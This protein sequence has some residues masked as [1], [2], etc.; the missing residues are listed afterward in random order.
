MVSLTPLDSYAPITCFNS[1][2][3]QNRDAAVSAIALSAIPSSFESS[4]TEANIRDFVHRAPLFTH[5]RKKEE[6]MRMLEAVKKK[7]DTPVKLQKLENLFNQG[8]M[9]I[10]DPLFQ[11]PDFEELVV[12][13]CILG[14]ITIDQLGTAFYWKAALEHYQKQEIL[15]IPLFIEGEVNPDAYHY[16]KKT[17]QSQ[18]FNI[19]D[20]QQLQNWFERMKG[21]PASEQ[22]FLLSERRSAGY[23]K[24]IQCKND[25][26]RAL[27]VFNN[28][29]E[30]PS[31]TA[32]IMDLVSVANE[33]EKEPDLFNHVEIEGRGAYRMVSSIGM[34]TALH[35]EIE[36]TTKS[37]LRFGMSK[38][39]RE[40]GLH[41]E[42]D[43]ALK[44]KFAK[45]LPKADG[46]AAPFEEVTSHD[47]VFHAYI[48][49]RTPRWSQT[50]VIEL[51]DKLRA[52][53]KVAREKLDDP[54]VMQDE[55]L[56]LQYEADARNMERYAT[57]CEDMQ[58]S[59]F[60]KG[61]SSDEDAAQKHIANLGLSS[62]NYNVQIFLERQEEIMQNDCTLDEKM[63]QL[64]EIK[65]SK[66]GVIE[67]NE[68]AKARL[69]ELLEEKSARTD[70]EELILAKLQNGQ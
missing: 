64:S 55:F 35:S 25:A 49:T 34:N 3:S 67:I 70:M 51:A 43:I 11:D 18:S 41:G 28:Y 1:T 39:L 52:L 53:A 40:N 19:L 42:R 63:L 29:T 4:P 65:L 68:F 8:P 50:I 69:R 16:M 22:C 59:R 32:T 30:D 45:T 23:E 27:L 10:R 56:T 60:R 38:S 15:E 37:V 61:Y 62:Y 57:I 2:A 17:F 21:Q 36:G 31:G 33:N 6:A 5:V 46:Y 58:C 24:L 44:S 12:L 47:L 66:K 20:D 14:K 9:T 48:T 7:V 26:E 13:A 54:V